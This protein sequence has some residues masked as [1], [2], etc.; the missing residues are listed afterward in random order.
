[1]LLAAGAS[2][3]LTVLRL[4][5]RCCV[6]LCFFSIT[7]QISLPALLYILLL[8]LILFCLFLMFR[9]FF[10]IGMFCGGILESSERKNYDRDRDK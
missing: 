3:V 9:I 7:E 8:L 5:E 2:A 6:C 4:G 10:L 1:M